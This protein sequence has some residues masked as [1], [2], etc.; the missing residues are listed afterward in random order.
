MT[1]IRLI[2]ERNAPPAPPVTRPGMG[3]SGREQLLRK[4]SARR[5]GH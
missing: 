5:G 3:M 1:Q 4:I 2:D